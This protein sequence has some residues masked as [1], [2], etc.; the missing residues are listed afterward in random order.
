MTDETALRPHRMATDVFGGV[1]ALTDRLANM[2]R[3]TREARGFSRQDLVL[4]SQVGDEALL[5]E[6]EEQKALPAPN[7]LMA[8]LDALSLPLQNVMQ[9]EV[10]DEEL[11]RY[12]SEEMGLRKVA[13]MARANGPDPAQA[14]TP[15]YK[16]WALEVFLR[17]EA[18]NELCPASPSLPDSQGRSLRLKELLHKV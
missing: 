9:I 4:Q 16:R 8:Y 14:A 11:E 15:E 6:L 5:A 13:L 10:L 2:V 1:A 17:I 3:F 12:W 18:L 7:V